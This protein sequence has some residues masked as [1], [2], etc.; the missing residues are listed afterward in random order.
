MTDQDTQ[1]HQRW[2]YERQTENAQRDLERAQN[3]HDGLDAYALEINKGAMQA[4]TLAIRYALLI[5]GGAAIAV[6]GFVGALAFQGRVAIGAGLNEIAG[7]L[8][9]FAIGV[10][11][12]TLGLG[13]AYL[14]NFFAAAHAS[15]MNKNWTGPLIEETPSS[16]RY[17]R[18]YI[19]F[20][21]LAVLSAL[22]AVGC[23]LCGVLEVK[24]AIMKLR[25]VGYGA[26]PGSKY[27]ERVLCGG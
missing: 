7:T 15:R 22:F 27:P 5:N 19:F 2:A 11:A 9:Y 8:V 6:L 4:G 14:T 3:I 20:L 18:W 24:A 17:K 1:A 16:R 26:V 23:F 21:I 13:W 10:V 12:G 25:P